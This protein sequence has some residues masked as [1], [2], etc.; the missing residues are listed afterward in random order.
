LNQCLEVVTI[1]NMSRLKFWGVQ[2][3]S[4]GGSNVDGYG[5]NT[6]CVSIEYG[7]DLIV[8]D[9]GTGI[10][11]LSNTLNYSDYTN[12][13]FILTHEHWDHIQGF[14]FFDF[15]YNIPQLHVFCPFPSAID[16]MLALINGVNFPLSCS[17]IYSKLN[18][19]NDLDTFHSQFN[20][21]LTYIQTHHHGDCVGYRIQAP[22]LDITYIPDNQLSLLPENRLEYQAFVTFCLNTN[23]MIHDAHLIEADL[24]K[25]QHWGHSLFLD[26]AQLAT[27]ACVNEC[28]F[29]HHEPDRSS[30]RITRML[31]LARSKYPD[32][33]IYAAKEGVII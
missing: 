25:K 12:V 5:T 30:T 18:I 6:A 3:S 24:P 15:I 17:D 8:F 16:N 31:D 32:L 26:T 29:F 19:M 14:P 4:P 20:Y 1:K 11:T 33:S 28:H 21:Q 13:I 7:D 2:G 27:D 9:A 10:R 23:I 22:S